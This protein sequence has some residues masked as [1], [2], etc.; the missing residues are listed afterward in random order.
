MSLD[1]NQVS[2]LPAGPPSILPPH[3]DLGG[4]YDE[5][6][7]AAGQVRPHY[8]VLHEQMA[9]LCAEEFEERR[10][11][12][13]VAFMYQGVTFTLYFDDQS[14]ERTLPFDLVPRLIPRAEWDRLE[15]GLI[16]RATALNTFLHDIYHQQRILKDGR[17][18]PALVFGARHFRR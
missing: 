16:Q 6:F 1:L 14:A 4:F 11:E 17:V 8:R 12:A 13:D 9:A 7:A 18:P 5:M 2:V 15:R 10:R 3:Y